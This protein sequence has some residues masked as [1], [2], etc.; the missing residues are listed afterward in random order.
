MLGTLIGSLLQNAQ[1]AAQILELKEHIRP[2]RVKIHC[3]NF[4]QWAEEGRG[5]SMKFYLW[6]NAYWVKFVFINLFFNLNFALK[7]PKLIRVLAHVH[8]LALSVFP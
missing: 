7:I 1:M 3:W 2:F 5:L 8:R 6:I 4:F